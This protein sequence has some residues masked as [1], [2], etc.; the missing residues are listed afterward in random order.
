M[1]EDEVTQAKELLAH[2][3]RTQA[4]A[5]ATL[6]T[7]NWRL[8]IVWGAISLGSV[9]LAAADKWTWMPWFW[10]LMPFVSIIVTHKDENFSLRNPR[11]YWLVGAGIF[12]GAW[13]SSLLLSGSIAIVGIWLSMVIGFAGFA[14]LD[15]QRLIARALGILL[16]WG[17]VVAFLLDGEVLIFGVL[18]SAL[19]AFLLALGVGLRTVRSDD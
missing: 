13:G 11:S 15:N 14:V 16:V 10:L 3:S 9:I 19:G 17:V 18:M 8:F 7:V 6:L 1:S 5:R 4:L 12:V 2:H